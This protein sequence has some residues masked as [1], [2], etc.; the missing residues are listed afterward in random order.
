MIGERLKHAFGGNE[1]WVLSYR[2]ECFDAIG[3][4]PSIKYPLYNGALE[5]ELRKYV[6][7]SGKTKSFLKEGHEV[8][9]ENE[10][11]EMSQSHRFKKSR[12]FKERLQHIEEMEESDIL[13]FTF[14]KPRNPL[15][16]DNKEKRPRKF[17]D[18]E[19]RGG[20]P[21]GFNDDK[22]KKHRSDNRSGGFKGAN[23]GFKRNKKD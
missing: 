3:L 6:C 20:K 17:R 14:R 2:K 9:T 10:R 22:G 7:F 11:K 18:N 23:R 16:S 21:R 19:E 5:C 1:A 4:K 15:L 12:E 13:T 8:K